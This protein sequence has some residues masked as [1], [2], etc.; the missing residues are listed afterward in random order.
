MPACAPVLP[1]SAEVRSPEQVAPWWHTILLIVVVIAYAIAASRPGHIAKIAALPDRSVKYLEGSGMEIGVALYTWFGLTRRRVRVGEIIGGKW[2][3]P[4][5]LLIDVATALLF[6]MVVIVAFLLLH[7]LLHQNNTA[8]M[9]VIGPRNGHE[10]LTWSLYALTAGF[11]EGF[12]FRGYLQRQFLSVFGAA[13]IAVS[14]QALLFGFAHLYQGWN[15][16]IAITVY[17]ALFGILACLRKSL[18]PGM[19]QHF[20]EDLIV[21]LAA[22]VVFK[23]RLI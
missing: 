7:P 3:H 22:F 23:R 21:G 9:R 14:L 17:G 16:V 1:A 6:W 5:D 11:C 18:R 4:S 13:W 2:R 8:L 15:H 20:G 19:M 12:I 10:L